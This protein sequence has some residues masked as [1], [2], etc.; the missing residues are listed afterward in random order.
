MTNQE[1]T[2]GDL[3]CDLIE[4]EILEK[5]EFGGYTLKKSF[6]PETDGLVFFGQNPLDVFPSPHT[7]LSFLNP[8]YQ[9]CGLDVT[10]EKRSATLKENQEL[11]TSFETTKRPVIKKHDN[12]HD[13]RSL[14]ALYFASTRKSFGEA[15]AHSSGGKVGAVLKNLVKR[16]G[17]S[18]VEKRLGFYLQSKGRLWNQKF[19]ITLFVQVFCDLKAGPILSDVNNFQRPGAVLPTPGKYDHLKK[20]WVGEL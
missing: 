9:S 18:E 11:F 12:P 5:N 4:K 19:P 2:V 16:F 10:A 1:P 6:Q 14:V 3:V 15:P 8:R 13:V 7:P 20:P 17:F